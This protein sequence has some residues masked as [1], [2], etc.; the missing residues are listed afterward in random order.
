ML[1]TGIASAY[2][3]DPRLI[4]VI[5]SQTKRIVRMRDGILIVETKGGITCANAGVDESN[6][7]E[8]HAA[9][10]P[11]DPDGSAGRIRRE[12]LEKAG[13]QVAVIIS[14][15]FGRPFRMGQTDC[16]IGVSG[17]G[18]ITDYIGTKDTF[19]R[20][21]RVTEMAV[22]DELCG[23]AEIVMGKASRIPAAV[24]RNHS[25]SPGEGSANDLLRPRGEDL[26]R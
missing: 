12:I 14:D 7:Q 6:I 17:M 9:L 22:A 21:L 10:L 1:S 13:R 20:E 26:F 8:G 5:L 11:K 23:A 18:P 4:E 24:I 3:R 25:V 16:A 19:G 15:T 2:D